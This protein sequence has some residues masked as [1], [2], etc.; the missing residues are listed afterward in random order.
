MALI[1]MRK[2][3]ASDIDDIM[4]I[5]D[6]AKALLKADGSTQ[7]QDGHPD[8]ELLLDDIKHG[9]AR[10]LIVDHAVAGTATLMTAADPNYSKIEGAWID[11]TDVYATIHRIAISSKYRGLKLSKFF[12]SNL[13]SDTY[14]Q[15]IHHMRIDTHE[16]N[17]RMQH[18]VGEFGFK[19]TGVV[20]VPDAIDGKRL[21][22]ELNMVK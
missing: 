13:I 8:R 17:R 9:F 1:Y 10:V 14:A 21:A 4:E 16:M 15:G 22:Y 6:E 7:W 20:Y 5:I 2:A 12:F 18:I 3:E 19:Y 11:T